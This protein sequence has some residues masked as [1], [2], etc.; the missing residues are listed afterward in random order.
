MEKTKA[1]SG[2]TPGTASSV[3]L[4]KQK[5][6]RVRRQTIYHHETGSGEHLAIYPGHSKSATDS[7]EDYKRSLSDD[8]KRRVYEEAERRKEKLQEHATEGYTPEFFMFAL[9]FTSIIIALL[10][11][12]IVSV[13]D[14]TY[15]ELHHRIE[16]LHYESKHKMVTV[17]SEILDCS[18][19]MKRRSIIG[20]TPQSIIRYGQM[21]ISLTMPDVAAGTYSS[22]A[23]MMV[24]LQYPDGLAH[25]WLR[26]LGTKVRNEPM[27]IKTSATT[28]MVCVRNGDPCP[29]PD[30]AWFNKESREFDTFIEE[31]KINN[32]EFV[33]KKKF[34]LPDYIVKYLSN[35]M[36]ANRTIPK[37]WI[38]TVGLDLTKP[39]S[40]QFLLASS[41]ALGSLFEHRYGMLSV[42][43]NEAVN[44][45][46]LWG[47]YVDPVTLDSYN[48]AYPAG[49]G[50]GTFSVFSAFIISTVLKVFQDR[51]IPVFES[52]DDREVFFLYVF[53]RAQQYAFDFLVY[54]REWNNDISR[55]SLIVYFE[56]AA[57]E[58]LKANYL[59]STIVKMKFL[60]RVTT[61]AFWI[62]DRFQNLAITM[63]M[64]R[65][66]PFGLVN[67]T[68]S[69]P[70]RIP[71]CHFM[72]DRGDLSRPFMADAGIIITKGRGK[73]EV[74]QIVTASGSYRTVEAVTLVT[75][76]MLIFR[77][78][79]EKAVQAPSL[80]YDIAFGN[81]VCDKK[82]L[83]LYGTKLRQQY[84]LTC[85]ETPKN[86]FF[87][88]DRVIMAAHV[89]E[90]RHHPFHTSPL[91]ELFP[92][93]GMASS[94][95]AV[96]VVRHA[97][98]EDNINR[99]W[100]KLAA[101]QNLADDNPMLS[102]RG[103][104]QAKECAA[105]F[106]NI[107]IRN[108]FASPYDRTMETAS[109]IV[110]DKGLLVKPEPGLCE[111]LHHCLNPPGFWE[112]IKL[113]QKY[114]LVDTKYVPVFTK[115]SLPK[116]HFAD[117]A[118]LPRIRTT[119]TKITEKYEGDL[120]LVS[121]APP[122]GAIHELWDLRYTCVGQATVSKFIE[123]EKGKFRLE[124]SADASHLSSQ[125]NL[126]PF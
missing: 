94:C 38:D 64:S 104:L 75:L 113:K 14:R 88:N 25:N 77:D 1:K 37:G 76:R 68:R 43:D 86:V 100:K 71:C 49:E 79:L 11:I 81:I 12:Y 40:E 66:F 13:E 46:Q 122:I 57:E 8:Y 117:N 73:S 98:R 41:D 83:D 54:S 121:H 19:Y 106:K 22:Y 31:K 115:Q 36:K 39:L 32:T 109:I 58:I 42:A 72:D 33:L 34:R 67:E 96:Y 26:T 116:E 9:V 78:D 95:R 126:R 102:Q 85:Q 108:V 28:A 6:Q 7:A 15:I 112:T 87:L 4:S 21:C 101:V 55:P 80:Y 82:I 47:I 10:V 105:R 45:I 118:C 70:N 99:N 18:L 50:N 93:S 124:F 29:A 2:P 27:S 52:D 16:D 65:M 97:E 119:V 92:L 17:M 24:Y 63:S 20:D 23:M 91:A 74:T 89:P 5:K 125:R 103:R 123:V 60:K 69:A 84:N 30:I 53:L 48:V 51:R 111:V 90:I 44:L 62:K 120:L 114:P 107:E 110:A 59:Q 56:Y 3:P 61:M 35:R